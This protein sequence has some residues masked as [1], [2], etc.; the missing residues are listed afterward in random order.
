MKNRKPELDALDRR[1]LARWQRDTRRSAA[2]LG[3][4]IGLSAAAVQRRLKRLR[5]SGVIEAEVALIDPDAG[6]APLG[7]IVAVDLEREREADLDAVAT[8][9]RACAQVQQVY[10]VTG[11]ADFVLHVVAA[12]MAAYEAF[13]REHLLA[14]GNVR[15][16]TTHV[17]LRRI[18]RGFELP[19]A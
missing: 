11:Q 1:L 15:S 14:D 19:F 5:E 6:D 18:K 10:Y 12:D 13:T 16:F 8:R 9:M 2:S 7:C 17:V 4:E 3:D